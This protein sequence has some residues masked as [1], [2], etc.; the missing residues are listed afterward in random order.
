MSIERNS[1]NPHVAVYPYHCTIKRMASQGWDWV[2]ANVA[3]DAW[4]WD[5]VYD[6]RDS[7]ASWVWIGFKRKEDY[8]KFMLTWY[9]A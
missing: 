2:C 5:M 3:D 6:S 1:P 7:I 4:A 8:L 9:N